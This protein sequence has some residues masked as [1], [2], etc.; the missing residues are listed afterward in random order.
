LEIALAAVTEFG[1][2]LV[3]VFGAALTVDEHGKLAGDF[4]IVG[5]RQGA[6]IALDAFFEQFDGNHSEASL[7]KRHI[8]SN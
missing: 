1:G 8:Q 6:T 7:G 3:N 2:N 4:I 5:D